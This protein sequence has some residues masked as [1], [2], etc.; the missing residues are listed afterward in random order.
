[1]KSKK[2]RLP[3][4]VGK[5]YKDFWNFKGRYRVCKG[6]RASKKSKTAALFFIY[7]MMKYPGAN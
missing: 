6:S 4:L 2:I 1:M 5:G 3:D 7:S